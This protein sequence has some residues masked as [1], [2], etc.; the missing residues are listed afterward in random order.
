VRRRKRLP[1]KSYENKA[2]M[3]DV[4][5]GDKHTQYEELEFEFDEDLLKVGGW[6][7]RNQGSR[8]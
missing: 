8:W 3:R 1:S 5:Q 2:P 7:Y 6:R 4:D